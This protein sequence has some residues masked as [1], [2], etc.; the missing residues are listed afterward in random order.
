MQKKKTFIHS[1]D[2]SICYIERP[3]NN[4]FFF[5]FI[6]YKKITANIEMNDFF[7]QVSI[8]SLIYPLRSSVSLKKPNESKWNLQ[9]THTH[10]M[11]IG[12]TETE[13]K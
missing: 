6:D 7:F 5:L 3:D 1:T 8:H 11:K 10:K 13:R 2:D 4:T 12:M 9:H